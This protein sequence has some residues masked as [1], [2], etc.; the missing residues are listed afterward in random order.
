MIMR[1]GIFLVVFDQAYNKPIVIMKNRSSEKCRT[2][3][4]FIDRKTFDAVLGLPP[5]TY[6]GKDKEI[7]ISIRETVR[8]E[9]EKLHACKDP[10]VIKEV[11]LQNV[12]SETI[13]ENEDDHFDFHCLSSLSEIR[14][15][16]I[17]LCDLLQV[18]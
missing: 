1:Y 13:K 5:Q 17:S 4:N 3:L 10:S 9:K 15:E 7:F 6:T 12:C 11:F 8:S 16:F 18:T 2:L 14:K